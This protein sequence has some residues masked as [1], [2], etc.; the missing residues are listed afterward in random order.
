M[1]HVVKLGGHAIDEVGPE[2]PVLVDLARDLAALEGPVVLVHGGGPQIAALLRRLALES[3]FVD[4][5]RATDA[6]TMEVV[7]MALGL[8]NAGI[9]VALQHH[10]VDAVGL[11]GP[12]GRTVVGEVAGGNLGRVA[13]HVRVR[14]ELVRELW[15]ARRIPVVSSVGLAPDGGLVNC[16]ADTV[17]GALAGAIGVDELILLSDVDQV[18]SDP[19]DPATALERID[20][21]ALTALLASGA[22]RDGMRPK[23][24]A[25]LDALAGGA[26]RI[27]LAN[28]LRPHALRDAVSRSIPVTEV[29][30]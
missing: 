18:R 9:V 25:A 20:G 10:G 21:N 15:E 11:C 3:H 26:R 13:T 27:V 4:G 14:P 30:A 8:V 19:D 17:A 22:L 12:D 23:A 28:G 1:S 2:S 16:N 7:A 6:A 29:T 24:R 5:L